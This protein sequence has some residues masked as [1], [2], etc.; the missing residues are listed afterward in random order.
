MP[1]LSMSAGRVTAVWGEAWF[2]QPDGSL[3]AVR[4]GDELTTGQQ[5]LTDQKGI[6]EIMP[7]ALSPRILQ[8]IQS[9]N[10]VDRSIKA[11]ESR[12]PE[13]EPAS[14]LN[15]SGSGS[16]L[17]GLRVE[18]IDESLQ[19]TR[20][21]QAVAPVRP[22]AAAPDVFLAQTPRGSGEDAAAPMASGG[23]PD[24][25]VGPDKGAVLP[26]A[27]GSLPDV[28]RATQLFNLSLS[29]AD[30]AG[31]VGPVTGAVKQV[32]IDL[33]LVDAADTLGLVA[34]STP[35]YA[36]N[37]SPLVWVSD[38]Q[39]GLKAFAADALNG[40][41]V[42]EAHWLSA[43][44]EIAVTLNAGLSHASPLAQD[45][46]SL[47]LALRSS[48]PDAKDVAVVQLSVQDGG[49]AQAHD[50]IAAAP[51]LEESVIKGSLLDGATFGLDGFGGVHQVMVGA[52]AH[53]ADPTLPNMTIQ[54]QHGGSLTINV[55]TG[56]Y[57]YVPPEDVRDFTL[58][59]VRVTL[60]D[61]D[62]DA[63]DISLDLVINHPVW[64]DSTPGFDLMNGHR[65][66][67]VFRWHLGEA[68]LPSS[69][70]VN[71]VDMV[72]GFELGSPRFQGADVLDL[73]DLLQGEHAAG[74]G[75]ALSHYLAVE[76]LPTMS[77]VLHISSTGRFDGEHPQPELQDHAIILSG[78]N[79]RAGL[80]LGASAS[81]SEVINALLKQGNLLVDP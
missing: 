17:P 52:Q 11:I 57:S 73:R 76:T 33:T 51:R 35:L 74:G 61:G 43:T 6:V 7:A 77:T 36:S 27:D 66:T 54:T 48:A 79:L 60:L 24:P 8:Y 20:F 29:E 25:T 44:G 78:V 23:L 15:A 12:E 69:A 31:G 4:V 63:V 5:V 19:P 3:K 34:P 47:D 32:Q 72:K 62:G 14:G 80:G 10:E 68:H 56:D 65:G 45:V 49:P 50:L 26:P 37:G 16:L 30:V 2:R 22:V 1:I 38:G 42:L 81:S 67:D 55:L 58:D 75:D 70:M 46:L 18:R 53:L 71:S 21:A 28:G 13:F 41:P 9:A 40:A 59:P 39:G 64:V